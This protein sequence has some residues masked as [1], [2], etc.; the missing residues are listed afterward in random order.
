MVLLNQ[1]LK[2]GDANSAIC[3]LD[4][5]NNSVTSEWNVICIRL[6]FWWFVESSTRLKIFQETLNDTRKF[7]GYVK[8]T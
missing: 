4:Y 1:N 8:E 6:S 2:S 3:H 5:M 7:E